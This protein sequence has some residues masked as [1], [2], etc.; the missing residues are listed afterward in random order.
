MVMWRVLPVA[1]VIANL[2]FCSIFGDNLKQHAHLWQTNRSFVESTAGM[3]MMY[4]HLYQVCL[5]EADC[6]QVLVL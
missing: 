3:M 5:D 4:S 1:D 2:N 6:H